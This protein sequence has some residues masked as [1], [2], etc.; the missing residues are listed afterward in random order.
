MKTTEIFI[1][2]GAT[3]LHKYGATTPIKEESILAR[4]RSAFEE[5]FLDGERRLNAARKKNK[6]RLAIVVMAVLGTIIFFWALS[7]YSQNLS[8]PCDTVEDGYTCTPNISHFWGQYS[9]YFSVPSDIPDDIPEQCEVTF[10][11][12]LS[13]HG[14]RDPTASKSAYYGQLISEIQGNAT[15]Y[16]SGYAF[17]KD[18]KYQMG[19]DQLSRFGEQEMINSGIKYYNR[20]KTISRDVTPVIRASGQ[21]RVV[22]SAEKW[23]KGFHD[24]RL[25]DSKSPD[26]PTFP[27]RII[28]IEEGPKINNTLNHGQCA[29]FETGPASKISQSAEKIWASIF[30]PN[31][32]ARLSEN[33]PG[34]T[35]TMENT[36]Y[37]MDLCPFDT[38][39]DEMGTISPFCSLFTEEEWRAYDYYQSLKKYYGYSWGNP[40]GPT[41][42]VGFTNELIARLTNSPVDDSTSTNTTLDSNPDTFPL[43]DN[44]RLYADFTHDNDMITIFSAMGLFNST[45]PLLNTTIESAEEMKGYSTSWNVPFAARAYVE[46]LRC[47]GV[48]QEL[49]RVSLNDR[50]IPLETCG[51]DSLGRCTV[52]N[53]VDS[54]SFAQGDGH[55]NQC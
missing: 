25:L 16:G 35:F 6:R 48:D 45:A 3:D 49:V 33:L 1:Q 19:A 15:S 34:V 44:I 30:T 36:I 27:Y 37:M 14:A 29:Q 32:T 4:R 9:P 18:Y 8:I 55:W 53:F 42:G 51:A 13:R 20:Y 23:M 38:V 52:R 17:L 5:Q 10:A 41:Q 50:V 21:Q 39:A 43:G 7:G 46:K 22:E 31:I 24:A 2:P 47:A 11:Q 54:L 28:T 12:I 40:L 26:I